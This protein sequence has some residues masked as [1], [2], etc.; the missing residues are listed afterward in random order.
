[1]APEENIHR[2]Y[3]SPKAFTYWHNDD[4][5]WTWNNKQLHLE[6]VTDSLLSG[7]V[8]RCM[9]SGEN[10]ATVVNK[11]VAEEFDI[12]GKPNM[13]IT[14]FNLNLNAEGIG[15][16]PIIHI[17]ESKI[18]TMAIKAYKSKQRMGLIKNTPNKV[19]RHAIQKILPSKQV[20]VVIPFANKLECLFPNTIIFRDVYE[21]FLDY[22]SASAAGHQYQR[23]KKEGK[24]VAIWDDCLIACITMEQMF[25]TAQMVSTTLKDN[26]VLEFIKKHPNCTKKDIEAVVSGDYLYRAKGL[27]KLEENGFITSATDMHPMANRLVKFYKVVPENKVVK[28]NNIWN[29]DWCYGTLMDGQKKFLKSIENYQSSK[30]PVIVPDNPSRTSGT[31]VLWYY[32]KLEN[33]YTKENEQF[34][35]L[36]KPKVTIV[37]DFQPKRLDS[38]WST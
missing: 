20:E 6:D 21:R 14:A 28:L 25:S 8:F 23:E 29:Y 27:D 2:S 5:L 17:D 9:A 19:L 26:N 10:K 12:N 13:T 15:R 24:V 4:E 30:V 33:A 18:Q 32:Y 11:Q 34:Q 7:E 16:F 3:I 1:M 36:Y 37:P 38:K 31:M 35:L 22:I